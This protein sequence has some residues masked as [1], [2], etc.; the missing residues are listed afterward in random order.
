MA[1]LQ[2]AILLNGTAADEAEFTHSI[3]IKPSSGYLTFR[4]SVSI[5]SIGTLIVLFDTSV[6]IMA[7]CAITDHGARENR[8][9][10]RTVRVLDRRWR[11]QYSFIQGEYNIRLPDGTIQPGTEKT[12]QELATLLFTA[13]GETTFDVT[14]LPNTT[15]PYVN[16]AGQRADLELEQ[17]CSELG[18]SVTLGLNDIPR[19]IVLYSGL[20]PPLF[21]L[22][23]GLVPVTPG[24]DPDGVSVLCGLTSLQSKLELEAVARDTDGTV[25]LLNDLSYKPTEGW[26]REHYNVFSGVQGSHNDLNTQS[27]YNR[28]LALEDVWRLY[29]VKGFADDDATIPGVGGTVTSISQ[30]LPLLGLLHD[31]Q[32]V[33]TDVYK[34]RSAYIEGVYWPKHDGYQNTP[35]GTL[36]AGEWLLDSYRGLVRFAEPV[37]KLST[38]KTHQPAELYL[39]CTHPIWVNGAPHQTSFSRGSGTTETA[40]RRELSVAYTQRFNKTNR[41]TLTDNTAIIQ[42]EADAQM[43]GMQAALA[44]SQYQLWYAGLYAIEPDGAN[45]QVTW[46]CGGGRPS[47]TI[48]SRKMFHYRT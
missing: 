36:Y 46:R 34:Q 11:W 5:P 48:L 33:A 23:T 14:L 45:W 26:E 38:T 9:A 4:A 42:A 22:R 10:V 18:C 40:L 30:Y 20:T 17:L 24:D 41:T 29:R 27:Q 21:N 25:K 43:S 44:Q 6:F 8:W 2:A 16:W 31:T 13:M 39:T 35:E 12:P 7:G 1:D 47:T 3:G 32:E 37:V 28:I 15:R 19:I